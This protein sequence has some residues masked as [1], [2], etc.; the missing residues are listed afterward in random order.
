MPGLMVAVE[1]LRELA[2]IATSTMGG[3]VFDFAVKEIGLPTTKGDNARAKWI[4]IVNNQVLPL[5]KPTFGGS[6]TV[7]E[8]ESLKATM[9]DP[10]ASPTQ[11][12]DALDAFIAQKVRDLKSKSNELEATAQGGGLDMSDADLD[13]MI[14]Q[15]M[16]A[17]GQ[18]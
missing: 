1:N 9:G 7:Q 15:A 3:R 5:L 16:Q 6:F 8:G 13:A 11:K 12:M 18:R 14:Q 4:A 2:G 17:Q 10:N